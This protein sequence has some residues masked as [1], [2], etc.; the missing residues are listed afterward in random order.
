[1]F[2]LA[3]RLAS[4]SNSLYGDGWDVGHFDSKSCVTG[5]SVTNLYG[6]PGDLIRHNIRPM[7]WNVS[8]NLGFPSAPYGTGKYID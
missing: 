8:N 5:E 4:L 6:A 1:M 2:A 3:M 7:T